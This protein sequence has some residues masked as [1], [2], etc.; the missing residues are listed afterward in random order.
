MFIGY[1][2]LSDEDSLSPTMTNIGEISKVKVQN[3]LFDELKIDND[4]DNTYSSNKESWLYKT[5]LLAK[6]EEDLSAGNINFA[7]MTVTKLRLRRRKIEDLSDWWT[8]T[9]VPYNNESQLSFEL[10]DYMNESNQEY[11]YALVPVTEGGT[12][13]NYITNQI[14]SEFESSFLL[15]KEKSYKLF[16]DLEYSRTERISPSA[17][18]E[19]IGSKYPI[20][21]KNSELNYEQG[22]LKALT[23]SSETE[24]NYGEINRKQE[25]KHRKALLDFLTNGKAKIL[26]DS[27]GNIWC[28]SIVDTPSIEYKNELN[29]ALAS[30]SF[31]WCEIGDIEDKNDMY[32]LGLIEGSD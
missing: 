23:L 12:E 6:F 29:Q 8:I 18:L 27:N 28:V 16:Y 17:K 11:E 20:I 15:D 19:P 32:N 21:V 3:G 7:D 5:V 13:G 10:F 22:S 30:T 31:N 1:N 14:L 25:V 24:N 2:F 26:K 4:N 9:E